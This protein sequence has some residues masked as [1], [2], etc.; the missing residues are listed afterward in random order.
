M[1]GVLMSKYVLYSHFNSGNRGCEAITRSTIELLGLKSDDICVISDNIVV[2]KECGL[3]SIA[4]IVP[5]RS[6]K[7]IEGIRYAPFFMS[8][9]LHIDPYASIK[10]KYE[11]VMLAEIKKGGFALST[12]GDLYCYSEYRR[13]SYFSDIVKE[14][15]ANN[16]LWGCTID[17][18]M[19]DTKLVEE[20]SKYDLIT[21]RDKRTFEVIKN[22]NMGV[23]L[24]YVPDTAFLLEPVEW[25][26]S[27]YIN[28]K[29]VIG[30]NT[31]NFVIN[32]KYFYCALIYLIKYLINNT[33]ANILL[34]PHVFWK[35]Q[36]D[37]LINKKIKKE[38]EKEERVIPV[39][40]S[41]NCQ[42]IKYLI[43]KLDCFMGAR[44]HSMIAAYSSFVPALA[45]GY[46]VKAGYIADDLEIP[47]EFVV[48]GR[49]NLDPMELIKKYNLLCEADL[50][51]HL[52]TMIPEVKNKILD[53]KKLLVQ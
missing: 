14:I 42:Q 27:R 3:D 41:L 21:A 6:T 32:N 39:S 35:L 47:K 51:S 5:I 10:Y 24:K 48:D 8:S 40:E 26:V 20:L 7:G 34:I 15:G 13:L 16:V 50:R 38:F 29:E 17:E 33:E 53:A 45:F 2:D 12:G 25:D 23:D 52:K 49:D 4:K 18:K 30:I 9:K 31:S 44:T 22:L 11:E 19:I 1:E 37:N 36:N 46:S 28:S 43:S